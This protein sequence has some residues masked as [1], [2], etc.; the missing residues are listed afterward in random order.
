MARLSL[1]FSKQ[2]SEMLDEISKKEHRTKT[3][4]LRRALG[5]YCYLS[6]KAP[7]NEIA[8]IDEKGQ[9]KAQLKWL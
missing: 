1:E 9:V 3:E 7:E 8:V 2:V 6:E 5:L 4:I